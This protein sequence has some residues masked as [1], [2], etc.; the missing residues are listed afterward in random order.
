[1]YALSSVLFALSYLPIAGAADPATDAKAE[2]AKWQGTWEV[3]LQFFNGKEKSA[4]DRAVA[5]V[6]VKDDSWEIFLKENAKSIKG[7]IKITV[8]GDTKGFDVSVG[9]SVFR[10]IYFIDGDRAILRVAEPNQDRPKDFASSGISETSGIVI[11]KRV[12]K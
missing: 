9:E 4:K 2:L 7:T 11:Y 6:V 12:K 8:E 5:K 3:E 1:M 10:A